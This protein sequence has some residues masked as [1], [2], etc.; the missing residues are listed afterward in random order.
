M[1]F[2]TNGSWYANAAACCSFQNTMC[3]VYVTPLLPETRPLKPRAQEKGLA[4]KL[5]TAPASKEM[6]VYYGG[7]YVQLWIQ[8]TPNFIFQSG[9]GF[10][11]F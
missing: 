2:S 5:N 10:R 4:I 7:T 8:V 3:G 6:R 1:G 9:D 11:K